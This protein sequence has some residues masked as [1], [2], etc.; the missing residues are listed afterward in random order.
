MSATIDISFVVPVY[1]SAAGLGELARRIDAALAALGRP[2][3]IV[4]VDDGSP[5]ESWARIRE[6]AARYPALRGV[7]LRRNA[8]QDNAIMA[9]LR[10]ARGRIVV[11]MDDDLQHDPADAARLIERVEAGYDVCY[12]RF[13]R[14]RQAFWKNLG[15][16][17]NDK[18]ANVV[19]GKPKHIYMSPYKALAAEVAREVTQYDGPFPYVDG[20]IFRV[21]ENV[22]Q[23]EVPHHARY[24]G[25]GHFTLARSIGV[26]LRV[27]TLFSVVPLRLA[28][29]L[30][31]GFA[32]V[33]LGLAVYFTGLKIVN[34]AEPVGWASTIVAVLVLGGIQL[35]CLGMLG[36]YLGR[37]F[38]HLNKR[39]Q[40]VVK[41]RIGGAAG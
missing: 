18:V 31:F 26:W 3:E 14:K 6:L 15:S 1:A 38:L 13:P 7:R 35:A 24:A 37:V 11:V 33:G 5:D 2:G 32:A 41:E 40:Y 4:L 21:T 10:E 29:L 36:E 25:E 16:W 22:T 9:G 23:I 39:P 8:G 27:A 34:P 12:A 17:F 28:A 19:V 30:G 20:L